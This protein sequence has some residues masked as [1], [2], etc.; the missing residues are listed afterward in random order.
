MSKVSIVKK[1]II[2]LFLMSFIFASCID[3]DRIVVCT[4]DEALKSAQNHN[5]N[6]IIAIGGID[7][8][9]DATHLKKTLN[10]QDYNLYCCDITLHENIHANYCFQINEFP[11]YLIYHSNAGI[12]DIC[13]SKDIKIKLDN[14]SYKEVC[15][16]ELIKEIEKLY[17]AHTILE[18]SP[19]SFT[20]D[21]LDSLDNIKERKFYSYYLQYKGSQILGSSR[22]EELLHKAIT[23]YIDNP[24]PIYS[25]LFSEL[26]EASKKD[27]ATILMDNDIDLGHIKQNTIIEHKVPYVNVGNEKLL[28]YHASVSC[29]CIS[30]EWEKTTNP[31]EKKDI[32]VR[33][34]T[35]ENTGEFRRTIFLA[36]NTLEGGI[37]INLS[38]QII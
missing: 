16:D 2:P 12:V 19:T 26:L 27:S 33:V 32:I 14:T 20:K 30:V 21:L 25:I 36:A 5:K 8:L 3:P 38:G 35:N 4:F 34:N 24:T 7:I 37:L 18:Q 15:K 10:I 23:T 13:S 28:I 17:Y 31:G 11:S 1:L 22:T 9:E 29:S 6:S